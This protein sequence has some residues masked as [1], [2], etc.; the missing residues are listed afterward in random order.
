MFAEHKQINKLILQKMSP[1]YL[2]NIANTTQPNEKYARV[3]PA[4]QTKQ[5]QIKYNYQNNINKY[6]QSNTAT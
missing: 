4:S 1:T 5:K 3:Y 2:E 6:Y